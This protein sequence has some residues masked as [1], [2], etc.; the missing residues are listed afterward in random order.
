MTE[1]RVILLHSFSSHTPDNL[2]EN[3][4]KSNL[5]GKS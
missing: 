3:K 5:V 2:R 4:Q 1:N